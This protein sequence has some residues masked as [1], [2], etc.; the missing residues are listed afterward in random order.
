MEHQTIPD[1]DVL[2]IARGFFFIDHKSENDTEVN[3]VDGFQSRKELALSSGKVKYGLEDCKRK[4][5]SA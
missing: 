5:W 3:L 2:S 4:N 1:L